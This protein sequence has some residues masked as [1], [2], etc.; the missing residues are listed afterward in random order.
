MEGLKPA[1]TSETRNSQGEIR[2]FDRTDG[3]GDSDMQWK[4]H[5]WKEESV[6]K[7]DWQKCVNSGTLA[8]WRIYSSCLQLSSI[9]VFQEVLYEGAHK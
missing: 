5:G 3:L 4:D 9:Q 1:Y 2:Q 7:G 6:L 8:A